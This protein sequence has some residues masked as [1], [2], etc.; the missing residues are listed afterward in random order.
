MKSVKVPLKELNN[1]R[2]KLMEKQLMNMD[3]KIKTEDEYG[4]IPIN[5][6][7]DFKCNYEIVDVELEAMKRYPKNISELLK[8][9]LTSKEIEDLKTSFDIIGDI[10]IVEIPEM[11]EE[12]K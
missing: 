8:D 9:D 11:M 12:K 6:D 10:V 2:K 5:T 7:A 1:T 3:Y 4:F